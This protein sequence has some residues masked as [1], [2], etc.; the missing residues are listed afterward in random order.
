MCAHAQW[1]TC[2][3]PAMFGQQ[4]ARAHTLVPPVGRLHLLDA[5]GE[6]FVKLFSVY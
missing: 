5:L 6:P 1:H 3:P 4:L 2:D